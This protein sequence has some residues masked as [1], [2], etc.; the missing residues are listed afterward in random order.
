MKKNPCIIIS[1]LVLS[2]AFP[3]GCL[4]HTKRAYPSVEKLIEENGVK[5]FGRGSVRYRE[6]IPFLHLSGSH[7]E[8][9]YQYGILMADELR[10][11]F[12]GINKTR[13]AIFSLVPAVLRPIARIKFGMK[14]S[15]KFKAMPERFR[16][17]LEGVAAGSGLDL[18]EFSEA[19]FFPDMMSAFACTS[20]ILKTESGLV[21]GRNLDFMP[22]ILGR[23][24]VIIEY[25]PDRG[26]PYT[27]MSVIGC[28]S[29]LTGVND[30]GIS[31]SINMSSIVEESPDE[32]MPV[33]Y[34]LRDIL[35]NARSMADADRLMKDYRSDQGWI[36]TV[37]SSREKDGAIYDIAGASIHRNPLAEKSIFAVN[38]FVHDEFNK[39]FRSIYS[40]DA[41]YNVYRDDRVGGLLKS[42]R[43]Y[44]EVMEI[45]KDTDY[46]G[47]RKAIG[48]FTV[49]NYQTVQTIV[50]DHAAGLIYF[51]SA[52]MYAGYAKTIKYDRKTNAVSLHAKADPVMDTGEMKDLVEWTD[53]FYSGSIEEI[54]KWRG[55]DRLLSCQLELLFVISKF[56]G[57]LIDTAGL[58]PA[59]NADMEKYGDDAKSYKRKGEILIGQEKYGDAIPVLEAGLKSPITSPAEIM[60]LKALLAKACFKY[61][62]KDRARE[63]AAGAIALIDRYRLNKSLKKLRNELEKITE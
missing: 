44:R 54:K 5:K 36:L 26:T 57:S 30:S 9:G 39:S 20:I 19:V 15:D 35:E 1:L 61:D 4:T 33:G 23:Y 25:R 7:Y 47:H 42:A 31:I 53:L 40:S 2:L 11:I 27:H 59:I 45:L 60:D 14:A 18:D 43:G 51:S 38:R 46:H 41:L 8:M 17:E 48:K 50:M 22:P 52:P 49:N 24:P 28:L 29:G 21:H 55:I 10:S 56:D 13:D 16:D 3:C 62:Q 37:A 6:G 12:T 63:Y 34:K 32:T 58:M